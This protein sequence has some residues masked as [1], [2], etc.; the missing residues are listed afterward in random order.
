MFQGHHISSYIGVRILW[1]Q[2]DLM[3][4]KTKSNVKSP[5]SMSACYANYKISTHKKDSPVQFS[6]RW[7]A[8]NGK[9]NR[10]VI[11][12]SKYGCKVTG[13]LYKPVRV[14]AVKITSFKVSVYRFTYL[15]TL[16]TLLVWLVG[17]WT[18]ILMKNDT[19]ININ[20]RFLT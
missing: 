15:R 1:H 19:Y 17:W 3:W 2:V 13:F 4:H 7:W 14:V 5:E 8:P 20:Y 9:K 12:G 6:R 18:E 10:T 11:W 16:S